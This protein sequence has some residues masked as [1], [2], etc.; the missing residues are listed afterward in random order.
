MTSGR[1]KEVSSGYEEIAE[2]FDANRVKSL[3]EREYLSAILAR[4]KAGENV[5]DLG[6][7]S[8]EPLA[9]FFIDKGFRITGIDIAPKMVEMCRKRF[10]SHEWIAGDL[11]NVSLR[12][13]FD[14]I[15]A[16]DSFF[17]LD[18][19][20]QRRMFPLFRDHAAPR[21]LLLFNTGPS[22]GEVYGNMQGIDFY[23]ASLDADEY[24]RLLREH[25]FDI[26]MHKAEDP[27][28]GGRTV[29]LA[30]R[31]GEAK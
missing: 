10:P 16:F 1:S 31:H 19:E 15:L 28:C 13:T 11:R 23:H 20:A 8:G 17:H 25:G 27:D 12:Q 29:W 14:V 9:K 5:L 6:C 26:L 7:G 4:A 2:W 21:A 22:A 18:P 3:F 30:Q 24:R